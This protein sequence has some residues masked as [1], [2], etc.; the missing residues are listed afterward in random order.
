MLMKEGWA[1]KD[2]VLGEKRHVHIGCH[3]GVTA[4]EMLVPF[5]LALA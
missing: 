1:V 2:W 5:I 4:D 3:G